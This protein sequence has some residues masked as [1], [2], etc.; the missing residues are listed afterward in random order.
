MFIALRTKFSPLRQERDV[1]CKLNNQSTWRS[2]GA[3]CQLELLG[4][5][6]FAPPEQIKHRAPPGLSR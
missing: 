2:A 3:R 1:N 4:Y 5:K 6:H